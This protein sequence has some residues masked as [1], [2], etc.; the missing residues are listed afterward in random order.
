MDSGNK[1]SHVG[2]IRR[3]GLFIFL[4]FMS[5]VFELGSNG[6][7]ARL[8][9]G[10][11]GTFGALFNIFFIIT[12]PLTAVQLVVSK[13]VSTYRAL[14]EH[15]KVRTF[16]WRSLS[17]VA[18]FSV[19]ILLAGM[20][21]AKYIAGFLRIGNAVPVLLL[22]IV[23]LLYLPFPV[24]YGVTQGMKKFLVLGMLTFN[25]GFFR[26]CFG[27]IAV[28]ALASGINGLMIA[29]V[30]ASAATTFFAWLP[31]R[32]VLG[33]TG[34]PIEENE[35]YRAFGLVLPIIISLFSVIVLKNAD[36][37]FSK[38]FFL[39]A[40]TDA[41]TCAARVGSAFFM[42]GS[43]IMV[44]FPYVSEEKT[45]RRN[46]I[47]FLYKSFG[48]TV[49]LSFV[50]IVIAFI[51][52]E[53][54]MRIITIGKDIPG[55]LPLIRFIGLAVL[56]LSLVYI[57]SNYLLAKHSPG[58]LPILIAGLVLQ[59]TLIYSMHDS[60]MELLSAVGI[61]NTVTFTAML[62]YIIKEHRHYI[63]NHL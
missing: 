9:E 54:L 34:E 48:V 43:I 11:F 5:N 28:L 20:L 56:P 50:G 30:A 35:V 47:V 26:F 37:I 8:P 44:M 49:G 14:G 19:V 63:K 3:S 42:L 17:Y 6:V 59:I 41:Y 55:A 31:A 12:A 2:F 27:A 23:V 51:Y 22:M 10:G 18:V 53:L 52:P 32:S 21:G 29:M 7:A 36:I 24:F 60:P 58:F 61:A 38:K 13:E 45:Q 33:H 25:W 40:E 15:G 57:M 16:V 46:P 1:A 4:T 39:P 62:G